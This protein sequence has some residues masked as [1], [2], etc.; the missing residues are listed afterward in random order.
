MK[1]D[2]LDKES[3]RFS[4]NLVFNGDDA[5]RFG[6]ILVRNPGSS[7]GKTSSVDRIELNERQVGDSRSLPGG[8]NFGPN[9]GKH[10]Y[11]I[12][13]ALTCKSD[14]GVSPA[15]ITISDDI[16]PDTV[17]VAI[18]QNPVLS[19]YMDLFVFSNERLF[20][21]GGQLYRRAS[22]PEV[23][24][25][26]VFIYSA[27]D[28]VKLNTEIFYENDQ[29]HDFV[30]H[31]NYKLKGDGTFSIKV[32]GEDPGGNRI[33]ELSAQVLVRSV[34]PGKGGDIESPDG[35]FRLSIPAGALSRETFVL[36][37]RSRGAVPPGLETLSTGEQPPGVNGLEPVGDIFQVSPRN[38]QLNKPAVISLK[39]GRVSSQSV[40]L[41]FWSGGKW[42]PLPEQEVKGELVTARVSRLGAFRLFAGK[43]GAA[44][45][46][47]LA[48]RLDQNYPNPFN[49]ATRITYQ[50]PERGRV[51][52]T[53]YN[54]V[55]QAV[56]KLVDSYQDAGRHSILWYGR[57]DLGRS[58][59]SGVYFYRLK[60]GKHEAMKKMVLL[61]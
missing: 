13:M 41:F 31:G 48:F 61:K 50:L 29:D 15:P 4:G 39:T 58:V 40:Q 45:S 47:P 36:F 7:P 3:Y 8:L 33:S 14:S 60:Y 21:D 55:G 30:Y 35:R 28:T 22:S 49:P 16:K 53:I 23:E 32:R 27:D 34:V 25:P 9:D 19:Q 1:G 20:Q 26:E 43:A 2:K 51:E 56:R 57:D 10:Y 18:A 24:M 37:Y 11:S 44:G 12:T 42:E 46:L 6:V 59:S 54:V 5:N 17:S 38:L 52:L